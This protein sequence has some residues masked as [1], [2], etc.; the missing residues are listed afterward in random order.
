MEKYLKPNKEHI[1]RILTLLFHEVASS[2]GDG[3]SLWY[4][5]LY[6]LEEI[7][8]LVIQYN[9]DYATGWIISNKSDK[10]F[11]W[12]IDQEW[13]IITNNEEIYNNSADWIQMKIKT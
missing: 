11:N 7:K 2:G 3:D 4:T 8:K 9:D 13:V 12:G 5:R 10:I 6:D 1:Y